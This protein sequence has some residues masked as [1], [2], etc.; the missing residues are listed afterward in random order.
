MY[1][2][3]ILGDTYMALSA[4]GTW[5]YFT[6]INWFP[7]HHTLVRWVLL[8]PFFQGGNWAQRSSVIYAKSHS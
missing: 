4:P 2:N 3:K 1:P 7:P 6:Y 8:F 5:K